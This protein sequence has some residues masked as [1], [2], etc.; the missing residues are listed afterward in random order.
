MKTAVTI[1]EASILENIEGAELKAAFKKV[2]DIARGK[3]GSDYLTASAGKVHDLA[4]FAD[5]LSDLG[6]AISEAIK[7]A[8]IQFAGAHGGEASDGFKWVGGG[9]A[10]KVTDTSSLIEGLE[11]EGANA[12]TLRKACTISL[13]AASEATGITEER[14][15][16]T[17]PECIQATE[18]K[19]SLRRTF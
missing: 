6:S 14:L 5:K 15:R 10:Y 8:E 3:S 7:N 2:C 13:K 18:R 12:D 19:A 17:Y 16:A 4:V 9:K 1:T 11:S